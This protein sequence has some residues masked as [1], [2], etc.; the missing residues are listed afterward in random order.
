MIFKEKSGSTIYRTDDFL[1]VIG[2]IFVY[3][4]KGQDILI[5]SKPRRILKEGK[6]GSSSNR[7]DE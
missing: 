3:A 4:K 2:S 6:F 7:T 1:K 5:S